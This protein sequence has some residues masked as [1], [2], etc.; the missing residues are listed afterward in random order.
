[1]RQI[2]DLNSL[3]TY[4]LIPPVTPLSDAWSLGN[5]CTKISRFFW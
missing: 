4:M 1:M 2:A 3:A 5:N